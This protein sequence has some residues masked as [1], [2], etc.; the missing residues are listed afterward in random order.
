MLVSAITNLGANKGMVAN[1][2][3]SQNGNAKYDR[4]NYFGA[5]ENT[6]SHLTTDEMFHKID[7]WKKFCEMNIINDESQKES[8]NY[9]A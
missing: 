8:F 5:K 3:N 4:L 7:L 6:Q 9:L 1:G 2:K